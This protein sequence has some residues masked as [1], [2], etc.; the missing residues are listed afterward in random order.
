M[1]MLMTLREIQ[2]ALDELCTPLEA[3]GITGLRLVD[4]GLPEEAID[5]FEERIGW[6]LPADFR[7]LLQAFDFGDLTLGLVQFCGNG[8]YLQGLLEFNGFAGPLQGLRRADGQSGRPDHLLLI[9]GSDP[10]L[11]LLDLTDGRVLALDNE[12]G[13]DAA[14]PVARTFELFVRGLGTMAQARYR[15]VGAAPASLAEAIAAEV[16]VPH[17]PYW[18]TLVR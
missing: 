9:A 18:A 16:G 7:A 12:L 4:G 8:R 17:S 14:I 2:R 10:H 11:I 6:D 5:D 1:T 13:W 15:G 3:R